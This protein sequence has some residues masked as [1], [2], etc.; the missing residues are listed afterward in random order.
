M[1]KKTLHLVC[2]CVLCLLHICLRDRRPLTFV[3]FPSY[4]YFFISYTHNTYI[5]IYT[6][7]HEHYFYFLFFFWLFFSSLFYVFF[8]FFVCY[9]CFFGSFIHRT[10]RAMARS[11][12]LIGIT[13]VS[14]L[15]RSPLL[16]II[17]RFY[18][19][20]LRNYWFL[21]PLLYTTTTMVVLS[22]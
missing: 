1:K 11:E 15:I 18:Y 10:R 22:G 19:P 9:I 12:R 3:I 4:I 5:Y 17:P 16:L 14:S 21:R 8:V 2:V 7:T 13:H 20:V 6:H